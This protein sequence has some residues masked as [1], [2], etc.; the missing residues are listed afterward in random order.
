MTLTPTIEN[1]FYDLYLEYFHK[2]E[3][4]RRWNLMEDIPWHE[5]R[6]HPDDAVAPIVESFMAV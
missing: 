3:A 2:A 6:C 1:R 4:H 5:A